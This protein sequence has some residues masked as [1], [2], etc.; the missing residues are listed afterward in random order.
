MK[1]KCVGNETKMY[2][3]L[4]KIKGIR[5]YWIVICMMLVACSAVNGPVVIRDAGDV[6]RTVVLPD[7]ADQDNKQ[8]N[9]PAHT[10]DNATIGNE[11]APSIRPV[12]PNKKTMS[13]SPLKEKLLQQAE[14]KL[15]EDTQASAQAAI[16]LAERGLRLDRKDPRFYFILASAYNRLGNQTQSVFFAQQGL[17]YTDKN[18]R[19]YQKLEQFIK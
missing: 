14:Q 1:I 9:T 10:Q 6:S 19:I 5:C 3:K 17:R 16:V 4:K 7:S 2:K 8:S 12:S 18:S 11:A 15:K 13:S